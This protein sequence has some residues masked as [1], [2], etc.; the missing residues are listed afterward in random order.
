MIHR[1]SFSILFIIS[2]LFLSLGLSL[3]KEPE[4]LHTLKQAAILYHDSGEYNFDQEAVA[5]RAIKYLEMRIS[6]N[7]K[8]ENSEKLAVVFDIDETSLSNYKN[9]FN[10][11]FGMIPQLV[12]KDIGK[13]D[14]PAIQATLKLYEY[15]KDKGV[16]IFFIT[17]RRERLRAATE[18]NLESV[19]YTEWDG[20]FLKP[21]N[22]D[23]KSVNAFKGSTRKKIEEKGY[24]IV[25]NIGDQFSD[26]AGGYA[27][28]VFK[29]PNPYYFV[30]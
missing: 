16:A 26:L 14:D 29:L 25:V 6:Q 9:L 19:G 8:L 23:K 30:P 10:L 18:K 5:Q 1:S 27:E 12:V 15:A 11:N 28:R 24:T 20:L 7:K 21:N 17:G 13:A 3:A 22:Y 2:I 4:N